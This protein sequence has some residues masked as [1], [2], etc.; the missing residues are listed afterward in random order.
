MGQRLEKMPRGKLAPDAEDQAE[1]SA[2]P[3]SI[4]D[5]GPTLGRDVGTP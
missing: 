4:V 5:S 1:K 3:D 2:Q